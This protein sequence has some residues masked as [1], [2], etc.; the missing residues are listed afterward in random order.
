MLSSIF[1]SYHAA[2]SRTLSD[3]GIRPSAPAICGTRRSMCSI[4]HSSFGQRT[5]QA[6]LD[7]IEDWTDRAA[8]RMYEGAGLRPED[9]DIFNP[10]DGYAIMT[11]FFLEAFQW[12]RDKRGDAFSFYAGDT[13]VERDRTRCARATASWGTVVPVRPCAPTA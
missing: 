11:Q 7:E 5:R 1:S 8:R 9:V 13:R 4:T 2:E 6:D 12:H 10:H 3:I